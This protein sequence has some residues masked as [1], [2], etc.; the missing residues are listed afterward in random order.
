[1]DIEVKYAESEEELQGIYRLRY[2]IYHQEMNL[3]STSVDHEKKVLTDAKDLTAR[4]LC[5]TDGG[6]ASG[7]VAAPLGRRCSFPRGVLR[8]L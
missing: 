7:N 1:M 3:D 4:I 8:D 5:A 6:G 2:E